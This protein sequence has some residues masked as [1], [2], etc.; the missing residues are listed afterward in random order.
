MSEKLIK[1]LAAQN[2]IRSKNGR[3]EMG[4]YE[5]LCAFQ[6]YCKF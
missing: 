4:N 3:N 2:K 6:S 1:I 5:K